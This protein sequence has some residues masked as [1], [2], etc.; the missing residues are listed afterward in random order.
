MKLGRVV[1]VCPLRGGEPIAEEE[2][3]ARE[4]LSNIPYSKDEEKALVR[5]QGVDITVLSAAACFLC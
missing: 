3:L 2:P 4:A 1:A 5:K